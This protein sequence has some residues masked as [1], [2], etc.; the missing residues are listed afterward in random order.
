ML[1]YISMGLFLFWLE[2]L[3]LFQDKRLNS[4]G[5]RGQSKLDFPNTYKMK[6]YN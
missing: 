1:T 5:L 3:S 4:F 2:G 6:I